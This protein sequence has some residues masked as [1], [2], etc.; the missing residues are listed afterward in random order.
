MTT[1]EQ[2]ARA[3]AHLA[4]RLREDTHGARKWDQPGIWTEVSRLIGTNLAV[5][6][7]TVTRH[8]SDPTADTPGAIRRG[9]IPGPPAP[10][11]A[12]PPKRDQEC[13]RHPGSHA[14]GCSGC[15]ADRLS[16][17]PTPEPHTRRTDPPPEWAQARANLRSRHRGDDDD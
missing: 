14:V 1:T 15:A 13:P 9:F 16:H 3:L 5:A 6:C 11:I 12:R 17:T 10:P 7:E 8:A 4:Y 2:D